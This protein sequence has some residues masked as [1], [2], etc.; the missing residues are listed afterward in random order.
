MFNIL[1]KT[2]AYNRREV[3]RMF[4]V[5]YCKIRPCSLVVRAV[6]AVVY[7]IARDVEIPAQIDGFVLRRKGGAGSNP[8][9]G[10]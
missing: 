7:S 5:A 9:R 3:G 4:G 6:L 10:N 1:A 8:V 2:H